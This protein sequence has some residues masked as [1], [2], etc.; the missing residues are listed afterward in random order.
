MIHELIDLTPLATAGTA[1]TL[2]PAP[3]GAPLATRSPSR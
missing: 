1:G 2:L 3:A